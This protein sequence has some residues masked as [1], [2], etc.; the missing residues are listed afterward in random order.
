MS[1]FFLAHMVQRE[2][3]LK[4]QIEALKTEIG[5]MSEQLK[6]L[7]ELEAGRSRE[8]DRLAVERAELRAMLDELQRRQTEEGAC[9]TCS[10]SGKSRVTNV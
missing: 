8:L 7:L 3:A 9:P 5:Q 4:N 6:R 2:A 1:F 10:C